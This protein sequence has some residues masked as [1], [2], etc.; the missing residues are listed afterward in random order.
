[1]VT[2]EGGATRTLL[3]NHAHALLA[4]AAEPD[5][6]LRDVAQ[7]VGITDRATQRIGELLAALAPQSLA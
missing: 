4:I 5:F 3:T 7:R 6:R 1:M 2:N